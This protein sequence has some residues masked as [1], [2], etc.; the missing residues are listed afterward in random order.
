M[1][2]PNG[3]YTVTVTGQHTEYGVLYLRGGRARR[4]LLLPRGTGI[5]SAGKDR[6]Q[7]AGFL[8]SIRQR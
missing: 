5:A 6:L 2:L 1:P 7:R 4:R 8:P 3:L